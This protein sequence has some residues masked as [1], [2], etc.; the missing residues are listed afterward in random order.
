M[1]TG[2]SNATAVTSAG[3]PGS[4]TGMS[5]QRGFSASGPNAQGGGASKGDLIVMGDYNGDGKF[6]GADVYAMARGAALADSAGGTTLTAASGA[7]FG[8]QIRNGVL[9]KNAALDFMQS[10]TTDATYDGAGNPTNASAFL[11][12]TASRNLANDPRGLN[13]FNRYDV[14]SNGL[15]TRDDAAIIDHFYGKSF[16]NMG[17]QIAATINVNGT[18][19]AGVQKP[20][21]LVD[22]QQIDGGPSIGRA[23]FNQF[24]ATNAGLVLPA[25]GNFDGKVDFSDFTILSTHFGQTTS[26]FG[27]G[28]YN[29]TGASTGVVDFSDFTTLSTSFGQMSPSQAASMIAWGRSI[30]ASPAQVAYLDAFAEAHSAV[31]EPGTVGVLLVGAM[32]LLR[33]RRNTVVTR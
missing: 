31:P 28:D 19:A 33:R 2:D 27:A 8:D 25:D 15:V 4:I 32:G 10:N 18:L 6:N 22:V 21:S 14:N 12:S 26:Q 11:R 13:A 5:G 16:T 23:D 29:D 24:I 7:T 3:T 1:F 30:A 20:I 9:V 17:D